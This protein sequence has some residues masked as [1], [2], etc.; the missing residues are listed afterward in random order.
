MVAKIGPCGGCFL[1]IHSFSFLNST[2]S[3]ML[4]G[5]K[6]AQKKGLKNGCLKPVSGNLTKQFS[7]FLLDQHVNSC[8]T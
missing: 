6:W 2:I 8:Y 7:A 5:K 4:Y 3:S 1:H